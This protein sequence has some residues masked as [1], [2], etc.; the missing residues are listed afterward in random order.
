[1]R[2]LLHRMSQRG[3]SDL[4]ITTGAPPMIRV[5]GNMVP[6]EGFPQLGPDQTMQL[7]Y[8]VMTEAQRADFEKN[9][10]YDLAFNV[11]GLS[12]FRANIFHQ[13]G[14]VAGA[15]RTIPFKVLSFEDLGLPKAMA[16][17]V[18]RPSGLV[19]V[20]GPTGSGKS[21]TLASMIDK[22][23]SEQPVHIIT[24]EDPIE[25]L[26]ANKKAVINQ[27]EVGADTETFKGAL[28]YALRQ[29]P[30]V[31][32]VGEMRDL[33]TV[34]AALTISETGH[35]VFATLHT[36][37][38]VSTIN[39]VIDVF[40]PFQQ[41]QVR[42]KLSMV[43][44]GVISQTLI[45]KASGNGRAL[46]LEIMIPNA[47]IRNLIREEKVHQIYSQMQVGQTQHGMMT[48]NQC[49]MGLVSS[50]TITVEDALG[51]AVELEEFKSMVENKFPGTLSRLGLQL[52][53]GFSSK[54]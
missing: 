44:Q 35:L 27:R 30:D 38:C 48:L 9:L 54:R 22:I 37:S 4:H 6:I 28:K 46:G 24:I 11:K 49:L 34:E 42:A 39:R 53:T 1:M 52:P 14:A 36:N 3:A 26:H 2:D 16:D 19:L 18:N 45:P 15:F 20:T 31:V 29:D 43:L 10:E 7:C 5:D 51:R 21:T 8:S 25:F 13:R 32:L 33:E 12:R 47:A 50:S 41:G 40:P 17:L 23:N